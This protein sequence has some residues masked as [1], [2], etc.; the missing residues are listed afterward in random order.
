MITAGLAWRVLI[1]INPSKLH[2]TDLNLCIK[3]VSLH[4]LSQIGKVKEKD[5]LLPFFPNTFQL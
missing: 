3:T 1:Y 4:A 5:Q 2:Y